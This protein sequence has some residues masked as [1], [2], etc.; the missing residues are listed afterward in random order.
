V[1]SAWGTYFHFNTL[2]V[3]S[4]LQASQAD[5]LPGVPL[6]PRLLMA[7]ATAVDSVAGEGSSKKLRVLLHCHDGQEDHILQDLVARKHFG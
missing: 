5:K 1:Y 2:H 6:G 4:L 3:A 7:L